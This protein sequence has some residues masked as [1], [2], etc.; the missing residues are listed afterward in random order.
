MHMHMR[1]L[2]HIPEG[3]PEPWVQGL[4][5]RLPGADVRAWT[6]ALTASEFAAEHLVTWAPPQALVDAHPQLRWVFNLGAGVDALVGLRWPAGVQLVRLEDAGMGVQ[7]AEIACEAVIR[8]FRELDRF[9]EQ[10]RR[11]QWQRHKPRRRSE[12]P[13]G[14]LGLGVLG[15][16]VAQALRHF[17]F[18]VNGYS[19]SAKSLTGIP[20]FHGEAGLLPFLQ[21]SRH[22]V[23]VLPLTPETDGLLDRARLSQLQPGGL[24]INV[25]RGGLVVDEDLLSLLDTGHLDGAVLDVFRTEPLPADHAYWRHPRVRVTPHIAAH[26]LRDDTLDQITDKL[27]ALAHEANVSGRVDLGRGY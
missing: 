25:A 11:G 21:A 15:G 3:R 6:P 4:Q 22:L 17:E 24:V 1:I 12:W 2:V 27:G 26:T 23:C 19:R 14:V 5:Q 9:A 18:P 10:A 20:C 16:R 7:M 8:H 13:V